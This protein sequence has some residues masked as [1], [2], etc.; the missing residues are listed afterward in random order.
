MG[1]IVMKDTKEL[2]A[3]YSHEAWSGWMKYLFKKS[4]QNGDGTVI[5]PKDLV[6]RWTRQMYTP[7]HAL[8]EKEKMSDR[9][10]ADKILGCL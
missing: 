7:Y 3:A 10:E 4:H 8:P 2:L 1:R 9:E 5:I 6:D